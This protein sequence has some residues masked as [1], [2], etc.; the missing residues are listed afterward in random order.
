MSLNKVF[1]I[2][3]LI[4]LHFLNFAFLVK[5]STNFKSMIYYQSPPVSCQFGYSGTTLKEYHG[6]V[7]NPVLV[8]VSPSE[9]IAFESRNCHN[10]QCCLEVI[11]IDL[12][13]QVDT[14]LDSWKIWLELLPN[15]GKGQ[16]GGLSAFL[17]L[18]VFMQFLSASTAT[19]IKAI[20]NQFREITLMIL[21]IIIKKQRDGIYTNKLTFSQ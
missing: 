21:R 12:Q 8:I 19:T 11:S 2:T 14:I 3:Y 4:Y 10:W 7:A 9:S 6:Y 16:I 20:S 13:L 15:K 5:W 17:L 18:L 1:N